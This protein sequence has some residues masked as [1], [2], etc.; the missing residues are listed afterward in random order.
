MNIAVLKLK[1]LIKLLQI[2]LLISF[3]EQTQMWKSARPK[4]FMHA[5][6]AG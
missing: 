3:L 5:L 4:Y 1:Q 2:I 6:C